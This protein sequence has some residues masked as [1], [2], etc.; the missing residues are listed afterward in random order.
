MCLAA[1]TFD[2]G[3]RSPAVVA[4]V[5]VNTRTGDAIYMYGTWAARLGPLGNSDNRP[6]TV[7]RGRMR[8]CPFQAKQKRRR[9]PIRRP[10]LVHGGSRR[11]GASDACS[12][13]S[14]RA[15]AVPFT[16]RDRHTSPQPAGE[17]RAQRNRCR[18][19]FP[20]RSGRA[21]VRRGSACLGVLTL[22]ADGQSSTAPAGS[23]AD[24]GAVRLSGSAGARCRSETAGSPPDSGAGTRSRPRTT[25]GRARA[26][27]DR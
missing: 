7:A 13:P 21:R 20:F 8:R 22:L 26:Q 27:P 16:S 24:G 18:C 9:L 25:V 10:F 11:E 17:V 3:L 2:R 5:P 19:G 14:A 15:Q 1:E 23:P 4:P 6:G 12:E